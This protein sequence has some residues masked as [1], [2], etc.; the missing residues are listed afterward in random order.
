[1]ITHDLIKQGVCLRIVMI[2]VNCLFLATH[3]LEIF[4]IARSGATLFH[5]G[6]QVPFHNRGRLTGIRV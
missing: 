5:Q 4:V 2:I 3:S 1:M 6:L